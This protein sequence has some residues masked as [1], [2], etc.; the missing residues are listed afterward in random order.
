MRLMCGC[1]EE[2][3]GKPFTTGGTGEHGEVRCYRIAF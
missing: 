2:I 1:L 3:K